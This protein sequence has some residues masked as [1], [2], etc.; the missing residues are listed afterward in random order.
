MSTLSYRQKLVN[1]QSRIEPN[2]SFF[3]VCFNF[4]KMALTRKRIIFKY[5]FFD[6]YK[7]VCKATAYKD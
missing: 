1:P 5:N 7:I 3:F 2:L 4:N 6:Y